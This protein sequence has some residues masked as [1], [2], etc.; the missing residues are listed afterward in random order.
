M[1]DSWSHGDL[2]R[3]PERPGPSG[4]AEEVEALH[5]QRADRPTTAPGRVD[6]VAQPQRAV[7][8][9]HARTQPCRAGQLARGLLRD[10]QAIQAVD[11]AGAGELHLDDGV[12]ADRHRVRG[13]A[14]QEHQSAAV[15]GP[16]LCS[17]GEKA[18]GDHSEQKQANLDEDLYP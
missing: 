15:G 3:R 11:G 6:L 14:A 1:G 8:A 5:V 12:V 13:D 17:E 10:V 4:D 7:T 18:E 2:H 9:V 16:H